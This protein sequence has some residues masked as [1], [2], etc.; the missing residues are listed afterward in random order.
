MAKESLRIINSK[1]FFVS[2]SENRKST[3]CEVSPPK[4]TTRILDVANLIIFMSKND[5]KILKN[6]KKFCFFLFFLLF[7]HFLKNNFH[8]EKKHCL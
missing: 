5:Q 3:S 1:F 8:L 4:E 2:F 7:C 6:H